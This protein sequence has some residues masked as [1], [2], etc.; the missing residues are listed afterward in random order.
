MKYV[1]S[2]ARIAPDIAP[3]LQKLIDEN[4]VSLYIEPFCG[5]L[6]MMEHISCKTRVGL[7]I[8]RELIAFLTALQ[9]GYYFPET[10]TE[11][12]YIQIRDH[13]QDYPSYILGLTGFCATFGSKY[14]G[15]FARGKTDHGEPRDY[16][17]EAMRNLQ[18]QLPRIKNVFLSNKSYQDL[19]LD[20]L[21]G[22][23]IYCDPPYRSTTKY[24]AGAF[25]YEA[26]YN[27]CRAA[28]K[29]NILI[30]EIP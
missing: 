13:K 25:N 28:A 9:N 11:A 30:L 19:D 8:H 15:G 20:K 14:F 23:L 18:K 4:N 2:K 6:N 21:H 27:W 7:D 17:R 26:Y 3:I 24:Q 1:G 5:G 10:I 29:T 22:A 16:Y 12:D